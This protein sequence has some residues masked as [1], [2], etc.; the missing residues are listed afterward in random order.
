MKQIIIL[1]RAMQLYLHQSHN[2]TKGDTFFQD[3]DYF[4]EVYPQLEKDYDDVLERSIGLY[5]NTLS[6]LEIVDGV[7]EI[8][9]NIP[10][11]EEVKEILKNQ[12]EL[13]EKLQGY[14][15]KSIEHKLVSQ[16]TTQ[17]LGEIANKSEMR[18]YKI[19]QRVL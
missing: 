7:L 9:R 18:V 3:H 8:L 15:E 17:L 4:G 11:R 14:I 16:G 5:G 10:E 6:L 12:L 19:N 1:L 2:T 13:E